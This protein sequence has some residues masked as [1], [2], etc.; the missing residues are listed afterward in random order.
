[1]NAPLTEQDF[2]ALYT[3]I[4]KSRKEEWKIQNPGLCTL[5]K[6]QSAKRLLKS[7]LFDNCIYTKEWIMTQIDACFQISDGDD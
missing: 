4:L 7:R 1:M 2:D 6:V 5:E 3:W